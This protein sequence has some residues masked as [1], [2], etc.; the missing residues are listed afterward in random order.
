MRKAVYLEIFLISIATLI[1]GS[2][3]LRIFAISEWHHFAFLSIS[4]A[5]LGFGASG[6][7]LTMAKKLLPRAFIDFLFSISA[8]ISYL[9][10]GVI[11]FDSYCIAWKKIQILYLA[12]H[13]FF[14]CLPFFFSGFCVGSAIFLFS[15]KT[16]RIYFFNLI[17]SAGGCIFSII[18]LSFLTPFQV[19]LVICMIGILAGAIT[20]PRNY[21]TLRYVFFI[22]LIP[23]VYFLTNPPSSLRNP[24]MSVYKDLS[25]LSHYP[26]AEILKSRFNAFSKIDLIRAPGIRHAPGL[27]PQFKKPVPEQIGITIDGD[28]LSGIFPFHRLSEI[29]AHKEFFNSF[30]TALPYELE[31]RKDTLIIGPY[32]GTDL[33]ISLSHKPHSITALEI[34]PL[35]SNLEIYKN[36]SVLLVL[37][38]PRSFVKRTK[39]NFDLI[40]VSLSDSFKANFASSY[41]LNENYLYTSQAISNYFNKLT[42]KGILAIQRWLQYPPSEELKTLAAI[43]EKIPQ[44]DKKI[45][46]IRTWRTCLILVKK[47]DFTGDEIQ[48]AKKFCLKKKFDF[49]YFPGIKEQDAGIFT[50]FKKDPYYSG[51]REIIL[52]NRENFYENYA[53]DIRPATDNRPFF[54]NYF[55]WKNL[56]SI[57]KTL[58]K[59]MQP[60]AGAGYLLLFILLAFTSILGAI[61]ILLPLKIFKDKTGR[62]YSNVKKDDLKFLI[63]FLFLGIGFFF[64]EIPLISKLILLFGSPVYSFT[65]TGFGILFF[66]GLGS[67]MSNSFDNKVCHYL[68]LVLA[69]SIFL[70]SLFNSAILEF[71]VQ[72][73][74]PARTVLS[75]AIISPFA[76]LMGIPFPAGIKILRKRNPD[77]IPWAWAINGYACVIASV[78]AP[79]LSISSGFIFVLICASILYLLSFFILF[80]VTAQKYNHPYC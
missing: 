8:V 43:C 47:T 25:I 74:F 50:M 38:N 76:L 51:F 58:G 67:L 49:V 19:I 39:K 34:N 33:L 57:L 10:I 62:N 48:L 24:K 27:S 66:S 28:N 73:T 2:T 72:C 42:P 31:K 32:A 61:L 45:I 63:Y 52:G 4:I 80:R 3:L 30:A 44:P 79:I 75:I 46:A 21:R 15:E 36:P 16:N 9:I 5:L 40:Q 1:L 71:L 78:L 14:L 12:L 20:I 53:Y 37:E 65:I 17:G 18:L 69:I 13:C 70:F 26:G 29:Y 22:I 23:V 41:S 7:Y 59:T 60:F 11:P 35:L 64:F 55:K 54:F 77:L 6:T 68:L 56:P